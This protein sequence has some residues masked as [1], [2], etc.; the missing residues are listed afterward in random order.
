MG[1][2]VTLIGRG[3]SSN[4]EGDLPGHRNPLPLDAPSCTHRP[5]AEQAACCQAPPGHRHPHTSRSPH[6]SGTG[7][8][9]R[10]ERHATQTALLG[11]RATTQLSLLLLS[12]LP[13]FHSCKLGGHAVEG[14]SDRCQSW[15]FPVLLIRVTAQPSTLGRPVYKV[16]GERPPHHVAATWNL[17][18][19]VK[20][21]P[22][23]PR[24]G[25][26]SP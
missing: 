7:R 5:R 15:P 18:Q 10:Q 6:R 1:R 3:T 11:P 2:T 12:S 4:P 26:N 23:W 22:L 17:L 21:V 19:G 20:P 24:G 13:S 25:Q 9:C 8:S 16:C 14:V